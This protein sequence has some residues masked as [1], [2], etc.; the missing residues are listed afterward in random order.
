M[1]LP[2]FSLVVGDVAAT[3]ARV[4]ELG[5]SRL[6]DE[7]VDWN[8]ATVQYVADPDGNAIELFDCDLQ[9][10]VDRT[11]EMFPGSRP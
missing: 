4:V 3:V 5:G 8:G 1:P 7:P 9:A 6:W 11:L 10:I 2:H